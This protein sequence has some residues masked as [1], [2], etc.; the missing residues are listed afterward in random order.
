MQAVE[1]E[2]VGQASQGATQQAL[3]AEMAGRALHF[4]SPA[5]WF[6]TLAVGAVRL[7]SWPFRVRLRLALA[8]LVGVEIRDNLQD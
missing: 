6:F 3:L 7:I 1:E 8:G 5:A 2:L 4:P